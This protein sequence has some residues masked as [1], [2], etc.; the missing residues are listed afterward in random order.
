MERPL[1]RHL[2]DTG[3]TL[4]VDTNRRNRNGEGVNED[5]VEKDGIAR[6]AIGDKQDED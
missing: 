4:Q 3:A 2:S 1:E 5:E 6:A